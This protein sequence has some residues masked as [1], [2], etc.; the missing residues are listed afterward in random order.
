M[1]EASTG[2]TER[3]HN[4]YDDPRWFEAYVSQRVDPYGINEAVEQPALRALLPA[5]QGLRV[6]DLGCGMGYTA[7]HC[8]DSGAARVLG[9]DVATAMIDYAR[10]HN[11]HPRVEYRV[12]SMDDVDLPSGGFD[13][14]VSSF[15]MM[16]TP[17]HRR[18][19]ARIR[20]WLAPGGS[21]VYSLVHP[22]RQ[23]HPDREYWS[24]GP[25]DQPLGRLSHYFE[26][27]ERRFRLVEGAA[28]VHYH[29]TL[30]TLLNDV[31][32]AG[33][34]LEAVREPD[35]TSEAMQAQPA[36]KLSVH[37][38]TTLTLR[39][40][41]PGRA[42]PAVEPV[43]GAWPEAVTAAAGSGLRH[44]LEMPALAALLPPLTGRR[45][46]DLGC[47]RG[48][49]ALACAQAG[50]A[51]VL[52]LDPLEAYVEAAA[53]RHSHPRVEY[54]RAALDAPALPEGAFDVAVSRRFLSVVPALG[55]LLAGVG[56]ALAPGGTLVFSIEH[57]VVLASKAGHG[58]AR[59]EQGRV[60]WIVSDY[61]FEGPREVRYYRERPEPARFHRKLDT[62]F[63]GPLRAGWRL[64]RVAEP[65][66]SAEAAAADARLLHERSRP[67]LLLARFERPA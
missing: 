61:S 39:A 33:L 41:H 30:A 37:L 25:A 23:A 38:P 6:L 52:A 45:V 17:D 36:L 60:D 57:P 12:A 47:G 18:L 16:M 48:E 11:D 28:A 20:N 67:V 15:C 46:L 56:R 55:P 32:D 13:L 9:I 27:G 5:L 31:L 35:P 1:D 50:A 34:E 49:L 19:L 59:D 54:R 40:R 53:Q 26:Q 42:R 8:A 2:D 43:L 7:R 10:R 3:V 58:W 29:R 21:L 64:R 65:R 51:S 63:D 62:L 66:V 24:C 22:L 44:T 14:V 4:A